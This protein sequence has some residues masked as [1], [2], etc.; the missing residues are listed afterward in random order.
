M[1]SFRQYVVIINL[2]SFYHTKI[3]LLVKIIKFAHF[4]KPEV[5]YANFGELGTPAGLIRF[6][7]ALW[8][9][10]TLIHLA[11]RFVFPTMERRCNW[12]RFMYIIND[13]S[14][15]FYKFAHFYKP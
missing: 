14:I 12:R 9:P 6:L 10:L 13:N 8:G 2:F 4:Y 11:S 7:K 15:N 3:S 5:Y 1:R